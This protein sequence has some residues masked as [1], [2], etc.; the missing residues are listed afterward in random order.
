M[1]TDSD[2][3]L[4]FDEFKHPFVTYSGEITQELRSRLL[5]ILHHLYEFARASGFNVDM[6]DIENVLPKG[7]KVTGMVVG[8]WAN[9]IR[10]LRDRGTTTI[11]V[12]NAVFKD[13]DDDFFLDLLVH[14]VADGA[15]GKLDWEPGA[16]AV[17]IACATFDVDMAAYND[18][19]FI[20]LFAV[21]TLLEVKS[22]V[23]GVEG[24]VWSKDHLKLAPQLRTISHICCT[25]YGINPVDV[26]CE[27]TDAARWM[28]SDAYDVN[29]PNP[30]FEPIMKLI[31]AI[32]RE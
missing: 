17:K 24:G 28:S 27:W 14:R 12:L 11:N 29:Q 20:I 15:D 25:G 6:A 5:L 13:F 9:S 10:G 7:K 16:K 21:T 32:T 18:R 3:Q 19:V 2:S 30:D 26:A 4:T 22:V 8:H 31:A 23:M 1:L